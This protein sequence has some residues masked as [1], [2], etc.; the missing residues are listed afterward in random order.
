MKALMTTTLLLALAGCAN[1]PVVQVANDT[2]LL[3]KEDHAGIFGSMAKLKSDVIAEAGQ[4][5]AV[6]GKVAVPVSV[7]EKPVG[8]KP[9]E[10]AHFEYQFKLVDPATAHASAALNSDRQ[11]IAPRDVATDT[12]QRINVQM[13]PTMASAQ[14]DLYAE[15]LKLD[16]LRK[17][18]V[19]T[20]AEFAAQK[21]RLLAR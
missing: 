5:A 21:A 20:E 15:L 13:S 16:D 12:T 11:S 4:F 8:S 18:G 7:R 10:W 1:P 3:A 9:G 14:A 2:Y 6:R 19:L 17:R